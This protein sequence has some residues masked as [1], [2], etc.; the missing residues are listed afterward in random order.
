MNPSFL[1]LSPN[2]KKEVAPGLRCLCLSVWNP[3]PANRRLKGDL[4]YLL[5]KT[6]EDGEFHITASVSGFFVNQSTPDVFSPHRVSSIPV[7]HELCSLLNR[8][9]ASFGAR[10]G[11][12]LKELESR[13][14]MVFATP[15]GDPV[16]PWL[17]PQQC[18][19]PVPAPFQIESVKE[20]DILAVSFD[21]RRQARDWNE[22]Y[23]S[24]REA[25]IQTAGDIIERERVLWRLYDDFRMAATR[26]AMA[27]V[28]GEW[29]P[30]NEGEPNPNAHIFIDNNIFYC[31]A[32]E[33]HDG[34]RPM[35][36]EDA[37]VSAA[38][39]LQ[40]IVLFDRAHCRHE[41]SQCE[42][43]GLEEDRI[44]TLMTCV[45]DY[46]GHRLVAQAV[47]PGLLEMTGAKLIYGTFDPLK[48][49]NS[50]TLDEAFHAT[51]KKRLVNLG[52]GE[53]RLTLPNG[54]ELK[55][56]GSADIKGVKASDGR[57]Y[58]L[59]LTRLVPPDR[60]FI[61]GDK[62]YVHSLPMYRPEL[63]EIC[64]KELEFK[65]LGEHARTVHGLKE[66]QELTLQE[67][68]VELPPVFSFDPDVFRA[69][70]LSG[71]L[72]SLETS[73]QQKD[74]LDLLDATRDNQ[75]R[76]FFKAVESNPSCPLDS[77][78]LSTML[79]TRGINIRCIGQMVRLLMSN[80]DSVR[81]SRRIEVQVRGFP[82]PTGS[83]CLTLLIA[84]VDFRNGS[85][86]VEAYPSST[87]ASHCQH[88]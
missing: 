36:D 22:E 14:P 56:A 44:S 75:I 81:G 80:E 28:N 50:F 79:H 9:S 72:S 33:S 17:V 69:A 85:S 54:E 57:R 3:V 15:A 25:C 13:D 31:Y 35:C 52:C 47:V 1:D 84:L 68:C 71:N 19:V 40:G 61:S 74:T 34:P 59:D 77:R 51:L 64:I 65:R 66:G 82:L 10:I 8:L 49:T 2:L 48:S 42:L 73:Q 63:V 88:H 60:A 7:E 12:A 27:I 4:F 32:A 67:C 30:L 6:L 87:V 70:L 23:Q 58:V 45:V 16:Y 5:C 11:A 26:G 20:A 83:S 76:A 53:S 29:A 38:K 62:R 78:A 39:E 43:K 24:T 37:R 86:R 41:W 46:R 55:L 18:T 21:S